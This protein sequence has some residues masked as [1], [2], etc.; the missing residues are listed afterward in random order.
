[1]ELLSRNETKHQYSETGEEWAVAILRQFIQI[2]HEIEAE[3]DKKKK[4]SLE[5]GLAKK[6]KGMMEA[7]IQKG[8]KYA[9]IFR[10]RWGIDLMKLCLDFGLHYRIAKWYNLDSII[11]MF[12]D[13]HG[14][15]CPLTF[16]S[17][18]A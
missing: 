7:G 18:L 8:S 10:G 15:V 11:R 14:A 6:F 3:T 4:A 5:Q 13:K 17:A 1:M 2:E 9:K 12:Y 16:T